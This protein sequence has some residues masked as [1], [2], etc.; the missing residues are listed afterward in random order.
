MHHDQCT[1][2]IEKAKDAPAQ[3]SVHRMARFSIIIPDALSATVKARAEE[4]EVS[5]AEVG[6]RALSA[7]CTADAPDTAAE[8]TAEIDRCTAAHQ[9]AK[10]ARDE[11][12]ARAD[13]GEADLVRLEAES[14]RLREDLVRATTARDQF[15]ERVERLEAERHARELTLARLEVQVQGL[16]KEVSRLE[17]HLADAKHA[18]EMS[19]GLLAA[20]GR[21]EA[22]LVERF[23][24]RMITEESTPAEVVEAV[25]PIP[26][27]SAPPADL[28]FRQRV[29]YVFTGRAPRPV[30]DVP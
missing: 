23:G 26:A 30:G 13:K 25:A 2:K 12:I 1:S 29:V 27:S 19:E 16:E 24:P 11:A 10:T 21:R 8:Y 22:E 17:L 7:W 28:T 14:E 4:E 3:R 9:A 20:A 6:R 18:A 15:A 5:L